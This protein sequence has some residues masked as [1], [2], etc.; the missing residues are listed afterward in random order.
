MHQVRITHE[1]VCP[2][3]DAVLSF[4]ASVLLS[5]QSLRVRSQDPGLL[6]LRAVSDRVI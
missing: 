6:H 2:P 4:G 5:P 1:G 3:Y